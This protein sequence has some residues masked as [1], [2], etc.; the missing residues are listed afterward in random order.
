MCQ[1]PKHLAQSARSGTGNCKHPKPYPTVGLSEPEPDIVVLHAQPDYYNDALPTP[2]D[3]LVLVEIADSSLEYDRDEKLPRYAEAMVAEVWIV[4]LIDDPI[5][6]YVRPMRGR[7]A[8]A[9]TYQ[10]GEEFK[11]NILSPLVVAVDTIFG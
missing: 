1:S 6:R 11:T 10:R 7:Y 9:V 2:E 3:V 5:E 8:E 4:N